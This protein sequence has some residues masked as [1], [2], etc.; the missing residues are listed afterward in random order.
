[1]TAGE[2]THS[3][4]EIKSIVIEEKIVWAAFE[5]IENGD[6]GRILTV[7]D[8]NSKHNVLSKHNEDSFVPSC[9]S[10]STCSSHP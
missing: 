9:Q 10:Q 6:L 3:V 5:V 4:L 1:M 8:C 2:L 7:A